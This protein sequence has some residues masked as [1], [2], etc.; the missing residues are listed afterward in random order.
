MNVIIVVNYSLNNQNIQGTAKLF[1]QALSQFH[2]IILN[3]DEVLPYVLT[4]GDPRSIFCVFL[5]KDV[6]LAKTLEE[7]GVRLL[8]GSN[9]IATCDDK[10]ATYLALKGI[11]VPQPETLT[12]PFSFTSKL[13]NEKYFQFVKDILGFPVII[14]E[15]SGSL[16]E[17]VYLASTIGEAQKICSK[18]QPKKHIFQKYI[19]EAFG[20]DLRVYVAD[21]KPIG[22]ILRY[23]GKDFRSNVNLGGKIKILS[24]LPDLCKNVVAKVAKNLRL[25]YGCV[26]LLFPINAAQLDFATMT[27]DEVYSLLKNSTPMVCEVNTSAFI[28]NYYKLT[29]VNLAENVMRCVQN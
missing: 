19:P 14:K 20:Y 15:N 29:G 2:P 22:N 17:Q 8:N 18:I 21:Q 10:Y 4:Q 12:A 16:G 28:F 23:N 9:T 11:G 13:Y 1:Y 6:F 26:D 3:N 27:P 5:D 7:M 25:N 24:K